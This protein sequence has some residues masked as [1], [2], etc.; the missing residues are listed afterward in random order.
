MPVVDAGPDAIVCALDSFTFQGTSNQA[1]LAGCTITWTALGGG[2][3]P[4][5]GTLNP[6]MV[7]PLV[8]TSYVL[9]VQCGSCVSN[10]DTVFIAVNPLPTVT[11]APANPA[12]CAGDTGVVISGVAV[13]GTG[14][15]TY[16]FEW[17]P[18]LG[19]ADPFSAST[20]AA[21]TGTTTYTLFATDAN[22][23]SS[24]GDSLVVTVHALPVPDAG[25]DQFTCN[26]NPVVLQGNA[27][28]GSGNYAFSWSPAAHLSNPN[29]A[30]P[31]ATPDTSIT[32]T[33]SV[34]DLTTGC[35]NTLSDP[36]SQVTVY[37]VSPSQAEAGP[38]HVT[39]CKG[40]SVLIG[41]PI[42]GTQP[43]LTY[44][45]T[46]SNDL[47][48]PTL[49]YTWAY[50]TT[51]TTYTLLQ[52]L[53]ACPGLPDQIVVNVLDAPVLTLADPQ[54]PHCPGTTFS[55]QYSVVGG[56]APLAYNWQPAS[57]VLPGTAGPLPTLR[58]D[59][60]YVLTVTVTDAQGC[61][62]TASA[63]VDVY[64]PPAISAG[65][66]V[67]YCATALTQGVSLQGDFAGAAATWLAPINLSIENPQVNPAQT[68]Q[69]VLRA[70][71]G[72]NC[73]V[74]DTA[75][76]YVLPGIVPIV[77]ASD[78]T[79][80]SGTSVWLSASGGL[81][82]ATF[83]WSPATGLDDPTSPTPLANPASLTFGDSVTY[84]VTV[85]EGGCTADTSITLYVMP[86]PTVGFVPGATSLCMP[87]PPIR[88]GNTSQNA[89][90]YAWNFGDGN[91]SS[92]PAPVHQYTSPG[93]YFVT[94]TAWSDS[95]HTCFAQY[96]Y[97]VAITIH[98]SILAQ[99]ATLPA[100]TDTLWLPNADAQ[101]GDQSSGAVQSFWDFGDGQSA[102]GGSV[103]H[104]YQSPGQYTVTLIT[105]N[106][107]GCRDTATVGPFIVEQEF[108]VPIP[109]VFTPNGDGINDGWGVSYSGSE[110]FS[111][112]VTDRWGVPVY[113]STNPTQRWL[114]TSGSGDCPAGT[115][116]YQV[117]IG[118]RVLVGSVTL[119]R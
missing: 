91:T 57:A 56:V 103:A 111:L 26:Q 14:P 12:F 101:F 15:G 67:Y 94:L 39:I 85:S 25:P 69:Y 27:T 4:D 16:S 53:G 11:L 34:T 97:P 92:A 110:D 106:A 20:N 30:N 72:N 117:V 115:Y 29:I 47:S 75:M 73:Q 24:V 21:P 118:T 102:T 10:S 46:P 43:H 55:P 8:S 70:V 31:T 3:N 18:A 35:A 38:P 65:P 83:A 51:T 44:L 78:T 5:A 1:T 49:G 99:I 60:S 61:A 32:Y 84:T 88:F 71:Y 45:W 23:C 58:A 41:H 42:L 22:G 113:Q 36:L 59:T 33:L 6:T 2:L 28:L 63:M 66:D 9:T 82:A 64:T 50:P 112:I 95:A 119:L 90:D 76:V 114:G 98:D 104:S 80:C 54:G 96:T 52:G 93:Q 108:I 81:G 48:N 100:I 87:A 79:V 74:F 7:A 68:E 107:G 62:A 89:V 13:G 109:N 40:D 86:T 17:V 116:F 37:V 105:V 19:L 77:S